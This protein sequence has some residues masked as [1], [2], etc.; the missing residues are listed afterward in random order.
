M[1]RVVLAAGLNVSSILAPSMAA[2][3]LAQTADWAAA[4]FSI[5]PYALYTLV[6]PGLWLLRNKLRFDIMASA[7]LAAL[8]G[9]G[10][11]LQL[12]GGLNFS[13]ASIQLWVLLLAG[14]VFGVRA[15]IA[16]T[17]VS[18]L[19]FALAGAAILNGWVPPVETSFWN[20]NEPVVWLRA[21]LLLG[22]FGITSALAVAS[23]IA[24]MDQETKQL[25]ASLAR[26]TAQLRA[27]E[28]AEKEQAKSRDALASAQRVEALARLASG[29]AHDFNNSLTI[30]T[31]SAEIAQYQLDNP[32]KLQRSLS[33]IQNTALSAAKMTSSLLAFGRKDPNKKEIICVQPL[34]E[35]LSENLLRLLPKDIRLEV[36]TLPAGNVL[37]DRNQLE[38]ALLNLVINARDAIGQNGIIEV[39]CK[40]AAADAANPEN[41]KS[42]AL[43]YVKDNGM[44]MTNEV[45]SKLFEPFFTTKK[46]GSGIG[47]GMALL[48]SLVSDVDGHI[49]V[50]SEVGAG[51]TISIFL[52]N[53][54]SEI[55]PTK[56]AALNVKKPNPNLL[57]AR[58]LLVEDNPDVLATSSETLERSG[59]LVTAASNGDDALK[60]VLNPELQFDLMCIDG[61]I[62]GAS[63]G[64]IINQV[65]RLRPGT[66]IVVCS[67]YIEEELVLRGIRAGELAYISKPYSGDYFLRIINQE[68]TKP[69]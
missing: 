36:K 67:G 37:M 1:R 41:L 44:G 35:A 62:P 68:L 23:T 43:L 2:F 42:N 29:V 60:I 39:G 8:L 66:P 33:L 24:R 55:T 25:R 15:V 53:T 16:A 50:T 17:A 32:E 45:K 6:F 22:I 63:S 65:R 46:S 4:L 26:E 38:R 30:I 28:L 10:F 54:Q 5:L 7:F 49:E 34:I 9:L 51:S 31:N 40:L 18:L 3:Y 58:I 14:L 21:G 11:I 48:Q 27:L 20:Q 64:E 12:R 13:S 57:H 59:Y 19:G 69:S 52:P 47:L 61:V 56:P